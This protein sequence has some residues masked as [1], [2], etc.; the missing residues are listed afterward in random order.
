MNKFD[1]IN[2][3]VFQFKKFLSTGAVAG[4]SAIILLLFIPSITIEA[5]ALMMVG[6]VFGVSIGMLITSYILR[7]I[8]MDAN[9]PVEETYQAGF[10]KGTEL[11]DTYAKA[12]RSES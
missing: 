12:K 11:N 4:V 3:L 9:K 5:V 2:N 7:L 1:I 6:L 10:V 8:I